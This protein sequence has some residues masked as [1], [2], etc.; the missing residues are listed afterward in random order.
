ME[1]TRE[2]GG[3]VYAAK[4]RRKALDR[5]SRAVWHALSPMPENLPDI[6]LVKYPTGVQG[7]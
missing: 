4:G 5:T 1:G 2:R 3:A 7:V 6:S